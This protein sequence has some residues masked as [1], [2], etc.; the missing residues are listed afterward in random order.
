MKTH[1]GK[2]FEECPAPE[3]DTHT[4]QVAREIIVRDLVGPRKNRDDMR[5]LIGQNGWAEEDSHLW[6]QEIEELEAIERD[7]VAELEKRG[8]ALWA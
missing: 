3:R 4:L 7:I 1:W 2:Q 8:V 6:D 5:A